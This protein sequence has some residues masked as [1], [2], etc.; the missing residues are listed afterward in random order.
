MRR[1]RFEAQEKRN[2][3]AY[4]RALHVLAR[5]RRNGDTLTSA[6]REEH[7][8]PR[9][10][11]KHVGVELK[12]LAEGHIQPTKVD[13]RKRKM[14]IPTDQGT[15]PVVVRG[16]RQATLLGRYMSAV[17]QYLRTGDTEKLAE[18]EGRSVG[19]YDLITDPETLNVLAESGSLQLEAI[20]ALPESSS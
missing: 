19:G 6:A 5:M 15:T 18:F 2:S 14:L 4:N 7:I 16:S 1:K 20:Y 9:T 8:D 3:K 17:G 12:R 11:R 13:R 10:V